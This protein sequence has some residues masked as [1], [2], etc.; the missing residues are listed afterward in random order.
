VSAA[1]V[2]RDRE[3][4]AGLPALVSA[5]QEASQVAD[6]AERAAAATAATAR[7]RGASLQTQLDN[8]AALRAALPED[9]PTDDRTLEEGWSL[10]GLASAWE[11][12][13]ESWTLATSGSP[14]AQDLASVTK[15][16][17]RIRETLAA[18][19]AEIVA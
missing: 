1:A 9:L 8:Y 15:R 16:E 4:L 11:T 6:A 17:Q 10:D 14:V 19:P 7:L 3:T 2:A 12:A 18:K 5:A 13:D